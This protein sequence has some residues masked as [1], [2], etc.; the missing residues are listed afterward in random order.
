[1][2]K[3]DFKCN[4]CGIVQELL[5]SVVESSTIPNCTLC[6]G[7]M[8]RVYTPPAISFKGPGFYKTD[9]R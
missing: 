5:L 7:P 1:M 4:A 3:Y 9:N 8:V 2:P 6:D